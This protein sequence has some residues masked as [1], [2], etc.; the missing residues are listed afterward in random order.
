MCSKP[1]TINEPTKLQ[2]S[3]VNALMVFQVKKFTSGY[4]SHKT[5]L[6][7]KEVA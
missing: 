4:Q 5:I 2:L 7:L 6:R 3:I 1:L